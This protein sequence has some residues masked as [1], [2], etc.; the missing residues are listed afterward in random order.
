MGTDKNAKPIK[1][2]S[3]WLFLFQHEAPSM[4]TIITAGHSRADPGAAYDF[5]T[6]DPADNGKV[7]SIELRT[8]VSSMTGTY[9]SGTT[10][11]C[12]NPL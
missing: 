1:A 9:P 11:I 10:D 5:T 4:L 6:K 12:G 3:G 8:S 2:T 7:F